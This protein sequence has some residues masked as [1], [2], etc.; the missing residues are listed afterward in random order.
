LINAYERV[1]NEEGN[2][3]A[4][5]VMDDVFRAADAEWRGLGIIPDSGLKIKE[6]YAEYDADKVFDITV[7][8]AESFSGCICGDILRG[9]KDP[10]DCGLFGRECTPEAPKGA[11]MVSSEGT[12][13]AWYQYGE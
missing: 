5:D 13:A 1:V 11:C 8:P 4:K 3:K 6:K 9:A 2:V 12:C 10:A 7:P